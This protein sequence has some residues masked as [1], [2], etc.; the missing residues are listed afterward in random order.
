[1]NKYLATLIIFV[2][3]ATPAHGHDLEVPATV[4]SV[5]DGDTIKVNA[6]PWPGHTIRVSVR[7]DGIDTPELRGKCPREKEM[8]RYA[9]DA[10]GVM[11]SDPRVVL[12]DVRN[13]KY[14]GRILARVRMPDG[15]YVGEGMIGLGLA[16]VYDGGRREGWCQ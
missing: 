1:M 3:L 16:R 4:I 9:R 11:L 13:G 14:A 2:G 15:R 8:A 10:L 7:I 6:H 12:E 5:Y